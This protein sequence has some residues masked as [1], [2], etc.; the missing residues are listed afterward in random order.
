MNREEKLEYIGWTMNRDGSFAA[1]PMYCRLDDGDLDVCFSLASQISSIRARLV[2]YAA[3]H[4][5]YEY[6]KE[7]TDEDE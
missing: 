5:P 1:A 3:E 6:E 4:D 7:L 2:E